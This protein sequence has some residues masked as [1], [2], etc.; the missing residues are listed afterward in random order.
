MKL[1]GIVINRAET[2]IFPDQDDKE[3]A[4][5]IGMSLSYVLQTAD[6]KKTLANFYNNAFAEIEKTGLIQAA[7]NILSE[8]NI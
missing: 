2:F 6:H 7:K 3:T 5:E 1:Q 4:I 8:R